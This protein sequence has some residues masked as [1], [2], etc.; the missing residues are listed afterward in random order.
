MCFA[1]VGQGTACRKPTAH[2]LIGSWKV[3]YTNSKVKLKLNSDRTFEQVLEQNGKDTIHRVGKWELT[4]FE[5]PTVVLNGALIVR[6]DKGTL[7][8]AD[9]NGAWLLHVESGLGT[10]RL[11]VNE[12]L[13]LYFTKTDK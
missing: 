4:D 13:G 6:D 3:N 11:T 9:S 2:D 7:E 1:V 10:S 5:G 8:S 12:D